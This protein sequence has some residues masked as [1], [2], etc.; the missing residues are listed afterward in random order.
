MKIEIRNI[1][2]LEQ[3]DVQLKG[4]TIIGGE[5]DTG[6]STVGKLLFAMIKAFSRYGQDLGEGRAVQIRKLISKENQYWKLLEA[7][8]D[9][10]LDISVAGD[11]GSLYEKLKELESLINWFSENIDLLCDNSFFLN[12][13]L[14]NETTDKVRAII[15]LLNDMK[16][17]NKNLIKKKYLNVLYIDNYFLFVETFLEA[18]QELLHLLSKPDNLSEIIP[19]ALQKVLVS[20]FYSNINNKYVEKPATLI[21]QEED[22]AIFQATIE[23]NK[24]SKVDV[25]Q[26]QLY[27]DDVIFIETPIYLQLFNVLKKAKTLLEFDDPK[28]TRFFDN[29]LLS[30]HIKDLIDKLGNA[31]YAELLA[32]AN[33]LVDKITDIIQGKM[34]FNQGLEDFVFQKNKDKVTVKAQNTASGTKAFGIIQLL[35]GAN[36]LDK[37][38]LL[39]IDEPEVHLHPKWQLQYADIITELVKNDIYVLITSH[40]PYL[41]EA[42]RFYSKEKGILDKFEVYLAEHT[43]KGTANIREV[44]NELSALYEKLTEPMMYLVSQ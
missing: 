4:L 37:T 44:S 17:R 21:W 32:E 11:K 16:I 5:N 40:S 6:K 23:N 13:E 36:I 43:E 30:L 42:I 18:L 15:A 24:V 19:R 34:R 22:K 20:E 8:I 28:N 3:A 7:T 12:E 35:L 38:S 9:S 29:G 39:I 2:L 14:I 10:T 27:F 1:G 26:Q 25:Q 41:I 33:P 31:H